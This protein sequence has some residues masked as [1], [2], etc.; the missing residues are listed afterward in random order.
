M[1]TPGL[2]NGLYK[3]FVGLS[4]GGFL[5]NA[6]GDVTKTLCKRKDEDALVT[7]GVF[8]L[9]RHPNYTG[10]Q[11]GWTF[12]FLAGVAS[13]FVAA[14]GSKVKSVVVNPLVWAS[15]FGWLG[16]EFVLCAAT[17]TLEHRQKTSYG[18]RPEYHD[19]VQRTWAGFK[20]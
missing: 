9:F 2:A 10:E 20:L 15:F 11:V 17:T 6:V 19:W 7:S 13:I 3:T 4:L 14:T 12:N 1:T 16:I 18:E 8:A 5:L